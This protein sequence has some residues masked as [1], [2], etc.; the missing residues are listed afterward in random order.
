MGEFADE[1]V[2]LG[3]K[4][5]V[6]I[7]LNDGQMCTHKPT[8][9][10][11]TSG[12]NNDHQFDRLSQFW[13]THRSNA[14][15]IMGLQQSPPKG[16]QPCCWTGDCSCPSSACEFVWTS[17]LARDRIAALVGELAADAGVPEARDCLKQARD[18]WDVKYE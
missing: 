9:D 18:V 8:P 10:N 17:T 11:D 13:W 15:M 12:I 3:Q 1:S 4:S 2:R 16:F 5:F 7:R 6:T 14:S